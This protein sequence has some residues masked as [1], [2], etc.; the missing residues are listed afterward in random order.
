MMRS[1]YFRSTVFCLIISITVLTGCAVTKESRFYTLNSISSQAVVQQS[2]E[3]H[4]RGLI[5]LGPVEIPDVLDRPQIVFYSGSNQLVYSEF[6]RWAGSLKDDI[7]QVLIK[8][9]SERL[10]SG[11][12]AVVSWRQSV[13]TTYRI[14]LQITKFGK[15][16]ENEV[17]L[18]ARWTLSEGKDKKVVYVH[19]S[20]INEP[21]D[22]Q[23]HAAVVTA[24]SRSLQS[25]SREIADVVRKISTEQ[26]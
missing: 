17:V 13:P 1:L 7:S 12:V 18:S 22:G 14:D 8:E 21:V 10:S 19:E 3:T 4:E 6:D 15:T 11:G 25:L 24:M 16:S 20:K 5:A 9:I 26:L 23:G 2:V